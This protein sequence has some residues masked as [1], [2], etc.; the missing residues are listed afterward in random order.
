MFALSLVAIICGTSCTVPLSLTVVPPAPCG[1]GYMMGGG[2]PQ[3]PVQMMP[4]V[5]PMDR[6][7]GQQYGY[8][9][10]NYGM[11][12]GCGG[13]SYSNGS[14]WMSRTTTTYTRT[15]TYPCGRPS[16]A[17]RRTSVMR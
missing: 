11:Q 3:P 5:P 4:M 14:W 6:C 15:T 1:G 9:G 10:G 7:G 8:G 2:C 12:Q 17:V 16:C 13:G